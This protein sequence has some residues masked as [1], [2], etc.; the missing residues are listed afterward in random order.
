MI[1]RIRRTFEWLFGR[2]YEG[3]QI[4]DR[5]IL[6][7]KQFTKYHPRATRA[8]WM[9]FAAELAELAYRAGWTR[10]YE[11]LERNNVA[12]QF[13]PDAVADAMDPD[14]RDRAPV[15]LELDALDAMHYVTEYRENNGN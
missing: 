9:V 5:I 13:N 14:W 8:E 1:R 2:W 7:V 12:S 11:Y 3:P 4:P 10:G 6:E 15:R